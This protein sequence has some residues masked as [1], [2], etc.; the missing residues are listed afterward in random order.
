MF[1]GTAQRVC[2]CLAFTLSGT[3][4]V[5]VP[6]FPNYNRV[7]QAN[8]IC[9]YPTLLISVGHSLSSVEWVRVYWW[10]YHSWWKPFQLNTRAELQMS[11]STERVAMK[12][13]WPVLNSQML[14]YHTLRL[15]L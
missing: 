5:V 3:D 6:Q 10:H 1:Q 13:N 12:A 14:Q 7:G 9:Q 4:L 11:E 15:G 2:I 8:Q